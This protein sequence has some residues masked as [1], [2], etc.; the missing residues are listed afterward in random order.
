MMATN[1]EVRSLEVCREFLKENCTRSEDECKYAHPPPYIEVINGRVTCCV[2]SLRDHCK[3]DNPPCRY[4]HPPSHLKEKLLAIGRSSRQ[5]SYG[6]D[7]FAYSGNSVGG[8]GGGPSG[9]NSYGYP[10]TGSYEGG[11]G[12]VGVADT[13]VQSDGPP[14]YFGSG[15]SDQTSRGVGGD[16]SRSKTM[17]V[18]REFLRGRCQRG[19]NDCRY[20]HPP[21]NITV[22]YDNTVVICMDSIRGKCSREMCRYFHPPPHLQNLSKSSN[23]RQMSSGRSSQRN[24]PYQ[25]TG[26]TNGTGWKQRN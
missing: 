19:D 20:A 15:F 11:F 24:H 2:D 16:Q 9:Y 26:N 3:R 10:P 18:C 17:E 13:A 8:G 6:G 21:S 7:N 14:G 5:S 1:R 23:S 22:G 4:M 12:G 25:S